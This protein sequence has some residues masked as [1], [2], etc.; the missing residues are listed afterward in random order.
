MLNPGIYITAGLVRSSPDAAIRMVDTIRDAHAGWISEWEVIKH[1]VSLPFDPQAQKLSQ[2]MAGRRQTSL[3]HKSY[4]SYLPGEIPTVG[5]AVA[6]QQVQQGKQPLQKKQSPQD[7]MIAF[8][9]RPDVVKSLESSANA[10]KFKAEGQRVLNGIS[11][12]LTQS[13]NRAMNIKTV[14]DVERLTGKRISDQFAKLSPQER[15][16][17]EQAVVTQVH[18]AV[19]SFYVK[20][21]TAE[22]ENV[23]RDGVDPNNVY[24]RTLQG[25]LNKVNSM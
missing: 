20:N 10:Q 23:K 19:K 3:F 22:I 25:I 9:K 18:S 1:R 4:G 16:K 21:L 12:G 13:I 6:P 17:A 14:Q 5:E 11:S 8:L 15:Q 2:R 24:I 7:A